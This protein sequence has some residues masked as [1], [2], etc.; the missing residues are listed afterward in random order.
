VL[1]G[2][3]EAWN[4]L[5]DRL[6]K[7]TNSD[8]LAIRR[9]YEAGVADTDAELGRL[10]AGLR[11][12]GLY[13]DA[14]V[15][16]VAD[17]G[18][19]L[20]EG[21]LFSHTSRLDEALVEVPLIVKWPRQTRG[22][23]VDQL[24]S[25]VDL[26]PTILAAAGLRAPPSDGIDL[27]DA[28]RLAARPFVIAEEHDRPWHR[29]LPAM[30]IDDDLVRVQTRDGFMTITNHGRSCHERRLVGWRDAACADLGGGTA[31][32][33]PEPVLASVGD[34]REGTPRVTDEQLRSLR[35]LGYIR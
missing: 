27:A 2:D 20:G 8:V 18:E 25:I 15:I 4:A 11:H 21:G 33:I 1:D 35:A 6:I 22:T 34:R 10:L 7:P 12:R 24:V 5:V 9:T 30:K 26:F 19:L 14:L 17:H 28:A 31:L 13:D 3:G 23:R 29:L 32:E 16:V